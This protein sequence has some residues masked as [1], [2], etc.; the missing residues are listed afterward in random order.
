MRSSKLWGVVLLLSLVLVAYFPAMHGLFIW[1]D[2][3]FISDNS[4]I[5]SKSGLLQIWLSHASTDYWPLT[6]SLFW[7]LWRVFGEAPF[8]YHLLNILVHVANAVMVWKIL[9]R[10]GF[11]WAYAVALIFAL[12][13]V[14]VEAVAWIFQLKTTLSTAFA[15][16]T[17]LYWIRF[18]SGDKRAYFIALGLFVAALLT[19][20]SVVTWPFVLLGFSWWKQGRVTL[21]DLKNTAPFCLT[22]LAVGCLGLF[23][24]G[25]DQTMGGERIRIETFLERVLSSGYAFWFYISKA[26]VP[27]QLSFVYPRWQIDTSSLTDYLPVIALV[28][29][30]AYLL[31]WSRR[32]WLVA[33]ALFFLITI[34]PVLGFVDI[35]F[36]R[37]SYVADHWQYLSLIAS[38]FIFVSIA[39]WLLEKRH[40]GKAIYLVVP[41]FLVLTF[42]QSKIYASEEVIWRDTLNKNPA[43]WLAEN[44]LGAILLAQ[45]KGAE[46][47]SHFQNVINEKP[48]YVDSYIN[49]GVYYLGQNDEASAK[50]YFSKALDVFPYNARALNNLAALALRNNDPQAALH[51]LQLAVE[52]LPDYVLGYKNLGLIYLQLNRPNDASDAFRKALSL[53]PDDQEAQKYLEGVPH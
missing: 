40:L 35:Y 3:T 25:Y 29:I 6:Y 16:G 41:L 36:M 37:Y 8:A 52:H 45:G 50:L 12:H 44:N 46:A 22:S 15:L 27:I 10:V 9:S 11:R 53:R 49:L 17:L 47:I 28:G 20:A 4:L 48:D 31:G 5:H 30:F 7:F 43:A 32:R 51:Y 33:G 1:D 38:I 34:F 26:L 42:Q 18:N 23:W 24:Y 2:V 39:T 21:R 13:P 14:N 19:K